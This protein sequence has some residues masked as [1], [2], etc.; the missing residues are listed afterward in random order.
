MNKKM[1]INKQLY[2]RIEDVAFQHYL[3]ED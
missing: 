1:Y 2:R 3:W